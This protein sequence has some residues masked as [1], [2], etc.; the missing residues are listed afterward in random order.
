[1]VRV[2]QALFAL[3][4]L[5]VI[6]GAL[7]WRWAISPV[8]RASK[9]P[10]RITIPV[11]ATP[12]TVGRQLIHA[13]LIRSPR[14]FVY[15]SHAEAIRPGVYD[16]AASESPGQIAKRL[17][18]GD[19][20]TVRVTFPEGFTLKQIAHRLARV[21]EIK[22][23]N[24]FLTLITTQGQTFKASVQLPAYLEGYLFPDT[25]RFPLGATDREIVQQMVTTFDRRVAVP[26]AGDVM[27]SGRSLGDLVNVASMIE[28]EAETEGDRPLI[29]GVIYNRIA[30]HMHLEL[31]A[32]VQYAQGF[33]KTRML[34]SD[35]KIDSP[36]NTYKVAGLP[37]TPICNP[38]LPSIVAALHPTKS[39][40]L[41]YVGTPDRSHVFA[42]TFAEHQHNIAVERKAFRDQK[43]ATASPKSLQP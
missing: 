19:F 18:R 31:D 20:V 32:T 4:A 11:G 42:R 10:Q 33:H 2:V 24:E 14:V 41:F 6:G 23:E 36:Y 3:V 17:A 7:W 43:A 30:R 16:I 29:A 12:R 28:R 27:A 9:T 34:F 26:L 37:P 8:D 38:G 25:Y 1:L 35:L 21:G 22:D 5:A 40:Y 13:G 39:D 15:L